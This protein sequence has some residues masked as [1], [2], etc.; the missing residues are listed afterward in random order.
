MDKGE[1]DEYGFTHY[2]DGSFLSDW[3]IWYDKNGY[4][5]DG[6]FIDKR[7]NW[8]YFPPR[9]NHFK[10]EYDDP[11]L[12]DF[13]NQ[14]DGDDGADDDDDPLYQ[15]FLNMGGGKFEWDLKKHSFPATIVIWDLPEKLDKD[16]FTQYLHSNKI[17]STPIFHVGEVHFKV[18][19]HEIGE[20]FLEIVGHKF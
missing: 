2:A 4:G 1:V 9:K 8:K 12:A 17:F 18:D 13:E 14:L 16:K 3:G 20:T 7:R 5:E 15:E 19:S 10:D 11:L 6:S